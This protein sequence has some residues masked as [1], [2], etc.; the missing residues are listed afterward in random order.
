MIR[1]FRRLLWGARVGAAFGR[2][3]RLMH[4]GKWQ[5]A[6]GIVQRALEG[7]DSAG[8]SQEPPLDMARALLVARGEAIAYELEEPGFSEV[9]LERSLAMLESVNPESLPEDHS[10]NILFL[11]SRIQRLKASSEHPVSP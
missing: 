8:L 2:A 4:S 10:L 7:L 6:L 5:V 11:R 1:F 3:E 9:E